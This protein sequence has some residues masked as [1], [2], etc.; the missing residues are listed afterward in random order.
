[1]WKTWLTFRHWTLC[2][3]IKA[4]HD[5]PAMRDMLKPEAVWEMEGGLGLTGLDLTRAVKGRSDWYRAVL[6]MFE[7]YDFLV[8]P[9]AQVF[10]FSAD[11]HWPKEIA[12]TSMDT[13]HRWMEITVG[14]TLSGLPIVNVPAGFDTGGRPMGMQIIGPPGEDLRVLRFAQ[15]YTFVTDYLKNAPRLRESLS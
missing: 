11:V 12:G 1:V 7:N 6:K 10:P 9:T 13:Y 4:L 5:D 8:L 15:T 2:A 3:N 14:G